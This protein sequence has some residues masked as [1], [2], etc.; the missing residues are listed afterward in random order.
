MLVYFA[1]V[2]K[3]VWLYNR[4]GS[5]Q[6][7]DKLSGSR[8]VCNSEIGNSYAAERERLSKRHS[9]EASGIERAKCRL[10]REQLG[11][12]CCRDG[13]DGEGGRGSASLVHA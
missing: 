8:A 12:I 13:L 5:T 4:L 9:W 10:R 1:A 11:I 2:R 7:M 6:R 3:T